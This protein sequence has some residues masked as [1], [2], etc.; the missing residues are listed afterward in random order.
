MLKNNLVRNCHTLDMVKLYQGM[1]NYQKCCSSSFRA[2]KKG[3]RINVE[4]GDHTHNI[5][6]QTQ[7]FHLTIFET[8]HDVTYFYVKILKYLGL[9][10]RHN[11]VYLLLRMVFITVRVGGRFYPAAYL[12]GPWCHAPPPLWVARIK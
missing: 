1:D 3:E 11:Q 2:E 7:Y 10:K 4:S 12:G 9:K 5:S 6:K 8:A